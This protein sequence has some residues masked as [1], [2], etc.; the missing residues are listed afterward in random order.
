ML[1]GLLGEAARAEVER[2][3]RKYLKLCTSLRS[4]ALKFETARPY[5]ANP[6]NAPARNFRGQGCGSMLQDNVTRVSRRLRG[7]ID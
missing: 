3:L 4:E 1:N 6:R 5:S 2:V 7:E